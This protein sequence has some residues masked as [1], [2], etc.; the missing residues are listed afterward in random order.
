MCKLTFGNLAGNRFLLSETHFCLLNVVTHVLLIKLNLH[1]DLNFSHWFLSALFTCLSH[2]HFSVSFSTDFFFYFAL[3]FRWLE[4][5]VNVL[6]FELF[7][8][9]PLTSSFVLTP[10]RNVHGLI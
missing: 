2:F 7:D 8:L 4:G 6:I 10:S 5:H 1:G 9:Y 3:G